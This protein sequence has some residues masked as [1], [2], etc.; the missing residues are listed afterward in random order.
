MLN[1]INVAEQT[2]NSGANVLFANTRYSSK[3]CTCSYGWLNHVEGS[4]LFTLANRNNYPMTVEIGFNGN[5]SSSTTGATT[6]AIEL[7]GEAIGGTE[8]DYTVVTADTFQN[9]S[10]STIVT[11]PT[12]GSLIVSIGNVGTTAT[13]VKDA[14][15]IIK[16]IS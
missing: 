4:G 16:R 12:G 13:L 14:N 3:R 6:L 10:T 7:N 2:V 11:V 5:V 8:M 1:A 9:V 15:I